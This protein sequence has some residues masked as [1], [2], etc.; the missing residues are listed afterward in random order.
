MLQAM[1]KLMGM[2]IAR[3]VVHVHH[4]GFNNV[5]GEHWV[6]FEADDSEDDE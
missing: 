3:N 6:E 1:L 4:F 2:K 5:L